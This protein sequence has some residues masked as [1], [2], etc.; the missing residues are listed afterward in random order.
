MITPFDLCMTFLLGLIIGFGGIY[1]S[2]RDIV[3][4][5]VNTRGIEMAKIDR[6][7]AKAQLIKLSKDELVKLAIALYEDN[8]QMEED[9]LLK[10]ED[11]R[12]IAEKKRGYCKLYEDG[13]KDPFWNC[14]KPWKK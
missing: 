7:K 11:L 6:R 8:S 9:I 2:W 5:K 10:L 1:F 14:Y 4:K 12:H 13:D 3:S